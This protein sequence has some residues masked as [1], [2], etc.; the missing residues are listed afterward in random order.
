MKC[1][2]DNPRASRITIIARR[3]IWSMFSITWVSSDDEPGIGHRLLWSWYAWWAYFC[4]SS[5]SLVMADGIWEVEIC[6][7]YC[8]VYSVEFLQK[9][10]TFSFQY[11][12]VSL[13]ASL[14]VIQKLDFIDNRF[15][16]S[17]RVVPLFGNL[18]L[19]KVIGNLL[20]SLENLHEMAL[21]EAC[22]SQCLFDRFWELA[23][24]WRQFGANTQ[25]HSNVQHSATLLV[26]PL[27]DPVRS[28]WWPVRPVSPGSLTMIQQL[29]A[30]E[31]PRQGKRTLGCP[32][33]SRP[34][35]APSHAMETR[36]E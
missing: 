29:L 11:S 25:S 34:A 21:D 8:L 30:C 22:R 33:L 1:S 4:F 24:C 20:L 7:V 26:A 9:T 23:L 32:R 27:R 12:L 5:S 35:R 6:S 31:G 17:F 16:K 13:D 3:R 28:V 19:L 10:V 36:D 2:Y 18:L 14:G 15:C